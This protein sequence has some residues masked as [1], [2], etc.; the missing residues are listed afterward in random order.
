MAIK[1]ANGTLRP[2]I[3]ESEEFYKITDQARVYQKV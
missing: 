1:I 3:N 2:A